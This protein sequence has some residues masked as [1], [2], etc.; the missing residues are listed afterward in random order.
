M[1]IRTNEMV[2]QSMLWRM[3]YSYD[4]NMINTNEF[5]PVPTNLHYAILAVLDL[6]KLTRVYSYKLIC[7]SVC[8][9]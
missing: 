1:P 8:A 7:V 4:Y 3:I 5:V 2:C 6:Y 9:P